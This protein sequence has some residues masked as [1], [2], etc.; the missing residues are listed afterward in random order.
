MS[1][2]KRR[3]VI[4]ESPYAGD[5]DRNIAYARACLR[6]C[7]MRG[8]SPM[9]SH[10]LYT[11]PGVLKDEDKAERELGMRAGWEWFRVAEAVV[12]Y[13]DL[14]ISSGMKGGMTRARK[15][16]TSVEERTLPGYGG[17]GGSF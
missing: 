3:L 11:Q 15:A 4:L 1:E 12:V 10:L 2:K 7:I 17:A 5:I 14:G 8:E 16:G 13:N 9:A 6:D